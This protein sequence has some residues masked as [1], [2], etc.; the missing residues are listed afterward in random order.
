MDLAKT[1]YNLACEYGDPKQINL[2]DILTNYVD[3]KSKLIWTDDRLKEKK[4]EIKDNS[5]YFRMVKQGSMLVYLTF[6]IFTIFII[7][8]SSILKKSLLSLGY[9]IILVPK[10]G[11]GTTVLE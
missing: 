7:L 4:W 10:L 5:N 2:T 8:I 9:I 11:S 3:L 6:H 1:Q